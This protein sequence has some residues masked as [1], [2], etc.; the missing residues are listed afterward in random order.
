MCICSGWW[1][2]DSSGEVLKWCGRSTVVVGD[3][4]G[5]VVMWVRWGEVL[6]VR[7]VVCSVD[8][9]CCVVGV[10]CV[11]CVVLV[12]GC[13]CDWLV[14]VGCDGGFMGGVKFGM[15]VVWVWQMGDGD[16]MCGSG[17]GLCEMGKIVV[18]MV[19]HEVLCD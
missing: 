1:V 18:E 12:G 4:G 2:G 8:D 3:E 14:G 5:C 16:G 19:S 15:C 11:L 13:G 9:V 6:R 17:S 10:G 7:S